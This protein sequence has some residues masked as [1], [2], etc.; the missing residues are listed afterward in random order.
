MRFLLATCVAIALF[1]LLLPT[2][3]SG[4]PHAGEP[5]YEERD[6]PPPGVERLPSASHAQLV[7]VMAIVVGIIIFAA[8]SRDKAVARAREEQRLQDEIEF[9]RRDRDGEGPSEHQGGEWRAG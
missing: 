8:V 7:W 5:E 6:P 3:A 1:V 9:E 2:A 4:F